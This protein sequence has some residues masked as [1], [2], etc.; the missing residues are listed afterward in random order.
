MIK[1]RIRRLGMTQ[2][3]LIRELQKRSI[4]V[5]PPEM[6]HILNGTLTTPKARHVLEACNEILRE[7]EERW[8][9]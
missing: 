2:V 5:Q 7:E 6:S 1:D 3:E 9:E 8:N 4:V